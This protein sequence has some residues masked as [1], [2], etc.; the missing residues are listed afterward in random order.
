MSKQRRM[1]PSLDS[2]QLDTL[3][4]RICKWVERQAAKRGVDGPVTFSE[5][6]VH[7]HVRRMNGVYVALLD[8]RRAL[9]LLLLG[10]VVERVAA[11]TG[12]IGA[13]PS[14]RFIV[15]DR[16]RVHTFIKRKTA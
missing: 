4:F 13:R 2:T 12:R 3:A 14:P 5:R 16:S 1:L 9:E 8:I 7:Q 6:S 10:H 15:R 11:L